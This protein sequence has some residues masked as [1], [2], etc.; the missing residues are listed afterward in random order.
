MS[1]FNETMLQF[2]ND[3]KQRA[4][5]EELQKDRMLAKTRKTRRTY[6]PYILTVDD[7]MYCVPKSI[8]DIMRLLNSRPGLGIDEVAATIGSTSNRAAF[9]LSEMNKYG[10]ITRDRVVG[11]KAGEEGKRIE[12]FSSLPERAAPAYSISTAND[13]KHGRVTPSSSKVVM[14]EDGSFFIFSYSIYRMVKT[15]IELDGASQTT[16][17]DNAHIGLATVKH[18]LKHLLELKLLIRDEQRRGREVIYR[19]NGLLTMVSADI[20]GF[21]TQKER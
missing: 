18:G 13:R 3:K 19:T 20:I 2:K 4:L 5:D 16:I 21:K 11:K 8:Y 14:T 10:L 9:L 7:K 15:L 17:V 1:H 12:H 6:Q